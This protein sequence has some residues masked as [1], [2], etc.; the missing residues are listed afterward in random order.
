MADPNHLQLLEIPDIGEE[1]R[2]RREGEGEDGWTPQ[3]SDLAAPLSSPASDRHVLLGRLLKTHLLDCG[4]FLF[5]RFVLFTYSAINHRLQPRSWT[6][7][8]Q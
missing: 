5:L 4:C 6:K 2:R 3:F 8:Q 1:E 7:L